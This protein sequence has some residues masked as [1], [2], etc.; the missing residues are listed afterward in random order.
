MK[1]NS[2]S[3]FREGKQCTGPLQLQSSFQSTPCSKDQSAGAVFAAFFLFFFENAEGF[4]G[5]R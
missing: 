2:T 5:D 1:L 4:D 3:S